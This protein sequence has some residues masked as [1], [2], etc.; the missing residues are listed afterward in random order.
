MSLD[1][2]HDPDAVSWV[3]GA[4]GHPEFPLA[5]LPLCVFSESGATPPRRTQGVR[6]G[7]F[8]V[9]LI[10]LVDRGLI[11]NPFGVRVSLEDGLL[12]HYLALGPTA[13]QQ[14]RSQLHSA[15]QDAPGRRTDLTPLLRP[16][17]QCTLY[18]PARVGDYTDFYA[19]IHHATNVGSILRPGQ[20]LPVNYEWI[21]IGYHGRSSTVSVSGAR[22]TRPTGQLRPEP[23]RPPHVGPSERLDFEVELGAWMSISPNPG[24]PVPIGLASRQI[25][26]YCLLNDWS[27]RDIQAWE[28]QPL[29]PFTAK[30]FLTTISPYL[31]TAEALLPYAAPAQLR[32]SGPSPLPYLDDP[33]DRSRGAIEIEL[34]LTLQ[35][36]AMRHARLPPLLLTR[37]NTRH[38]F[39]TVAQMVA[40]HTV[41]GCELQPGDLLGSGTISGPTEG[42]LGSMMEITRGGRD[43]IELP[44]G[45]RRAFLQDG[46]EVVITGRALRSGAAP[47]GFGECRGRVVAAHTA[48]DDRPAV[49]D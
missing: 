21:P 47:V 12:N 15:L 16:V 24:A 44:N 48:S 19:S 2:T 36:A 38:L 39:W 6:I 23:E 4:S 22:L 29:G 5:N 49:N 35:T 7:D 20:P 11:D 13:R 37:T 42:T 8:L 33:V 14:L 3:P 45:E 41:A 34:E 10:D 30:N 25:A 28:Y 17:D 27:A 43:P 46:D 32:P 31:V 26:G 18:L 1:A 9:P 40:H